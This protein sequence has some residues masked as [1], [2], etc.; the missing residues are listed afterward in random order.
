VP[1]LLSVGLADGSAAVLVAMS[2]P[3]STGARYRGRR[4]GTA[5]R[6][7]TDEPLNRL[8]GDQQWL[9]PQGVSTP[10]SA[11]VAL[12]AKAELTSALGVIEA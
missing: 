8:K 2:K 9:R 10:R 3:A 1:G 12:M 11:S 7:R 5:V 6:I 4:Y